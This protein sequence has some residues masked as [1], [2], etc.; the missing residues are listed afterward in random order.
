MKS[1]KLALIALCFATIVK[2]Q[3]PISYNLYPQ[4][5]F[6]L[7]PAVM[8]E[9]NC[10]NAFIN[11]QSKWSDV[12]GLTANTFGAHGKIAKNSFLGGMIVGDK[13][14]L[15]SYF[16]GN[17]MYAHKIQFK[18]DN[19]LSLGLSVGFANNSLNDE[20]ANLQTKNDP[21]FQVFNSNLLF[22]W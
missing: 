8:V 7:N 15:V 12:N 1:I 17:L 10:F 14:A 18:Q 2:A 9:D 11:R 20:M 13:R 5:S 3:Q 22:D 4:N 6:L 21:A 16:T 19:F